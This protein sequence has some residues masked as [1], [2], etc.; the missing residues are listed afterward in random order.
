MR[1]AGC[2][3]L[4]SPLCL[5]SPLA[6][7]SPAW[8]RQGTGSCGQGGREYGRKRRRNKHHTGDEGEDRTSNRP[9]YQPKRKNTNK[10]NPQCPP[11][12]HHHPST[13]LHPLIGVPPCLQRTD[14]SGAQKT[15]VLF[16]LPQHIIVWFFVNLT[17]SDDMTRRDYAEQK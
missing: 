14:T 7:V 8:T 6:S 10:N 12:H 13:R 16:F 4:S 11:T 9:H 15:H 2:S 1:S 3:P 17:T 5:P